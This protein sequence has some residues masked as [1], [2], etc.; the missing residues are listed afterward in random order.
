MSPPRTSGSQQP[1]DPS[2]LRS[3]AG[4]TPARQP[5][6]GTALSAC[7]TESLGAAGTATRDALDHVAF[8]AKGDSLSAPSNKL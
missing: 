2:A 5:D 8:L 3:A 7:A 6:P 4:L 1:S